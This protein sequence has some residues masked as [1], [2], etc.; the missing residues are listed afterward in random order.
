MGKHHSKKDI[1]PSTLPHI[2]QSEFSYGD[3]AV[4]GA[5]GV[6]KSVMGR[7]RFP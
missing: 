6:G 2:R 4:F 3:I 7:V 1:D 5:T